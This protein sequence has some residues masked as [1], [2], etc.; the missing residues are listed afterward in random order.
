MPLRK[1]L[2]VGFALSAT[3]LAH[4]PG[5]LRAQTSQSEASRIVAIDESS[6]VVLHG[7]RHPLAAPANDRGEAASDLPMERMLLV[8]KRDAATESALQSLIASQ[9]DRSSPD[10]HAWL[11]PDQFGNRFGASPADIQKLTSWLASHGFRV[12]RVGQGAMSIEFSG[13][14]GQ[15]KDAFHTAI[16]SYVVNGEKHYANA[17]DPQ[18]PAAF[19]PVVAGINTLHNFRK[20]SAIRVLGKASRVANTSMWQPEFTFSGAAGVEHFLAP[21]DFAK[22]YNT[23]PLYQN[24]IDGTGQSIA[25]VA[26][27][28]IH[29]SDVQIFRIAFGLPVNDPQIILDGPDPGNLTGPEE[30]EADLDVEWSG[31]IAPKATIKFVVSASTNSTDGVDLS[32]L[33]IVDNNLAPVLSASFGQ[34]EQALGQTE[35]TFFNNLWEQA[36]AQGITAVISSGDNGPA[37]CDSDSQTTP[38]AQGLAVNGLASTPFNIAVGGTQFNENGADSTYWSTTNGPDQSSALGYIPEVVW[39]ESCAD[40]NVCGVG[41]LFASSGGASTLYSKPSWQAGFGVPNDQKRDLPDVALDAAAGHDAYLLCQD[42]ICTTNAQGQLVNAELVGGTSAS[43]PTFA[44]IMALVVQK[45]NSRQG[46]AN[47][48]FYPLAASQND[49]NCNSTAAPQS[50]CIF[51]DITVGNNNVPGQTGFPAT[52]GYDQATGLGSVNA[53]NL[54]SNWQNITFRSTLTTLQ[55]SSANLTHGQ[56]VTTTA[57]VAPNAGSGTPTGD[58]SLLAASQKAVNLGNLASG[59][60]SGAIDTLPGGSYSVTASY[61]GDATFGSSIST[62]VPITI[63]PEPSSTAFSAFL[64]GSNP[65]NPVNSTYGAFLDLQVV[66]AGASKQGAPSGTLTFSDNFNG[67]TTMLLTSSLN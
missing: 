49:A 63:N 39:N 61:A 13:T 41:S 54:A 57:T 27:N 53:A 48:V 62:G 66:V 60:V 20:K 37:G 25:I 44:A 12:N 21:G 58:V 67:N 59:T 29:L 8:F 3:I 24:G 22:I 26:R 31:A 17:S 16:R 1:N 51:N 38:A 14:A 32:S 6:L 19:A 28:N 9:Q 52:V 33:Y 4:P 18:I 35:N 56:P 40:P 42:G 43:A 46:Q 45:T 55:L 30:T 23:A 2:L 15:V 34:C 64:S 5:V 11:S 7:N 10:F 50:T 65:S 36:A 47:F